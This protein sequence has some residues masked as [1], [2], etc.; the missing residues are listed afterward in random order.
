MN[1]RQES[2]KLADAMG[3]EHRAM[4]AMLDE[5][6][7]W[8]AHGTMNVGPDQGIILSARKA[9]DAVRFQRS[10]VEAALGDKAPA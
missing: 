1:F 9:H 5:M 6:D 4:G 3:S 7:R 8:S 10:R 2:R